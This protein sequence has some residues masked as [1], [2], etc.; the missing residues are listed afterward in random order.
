MNPAIQS[1]KQVELWHHF[2]QFHTL[3]LSVLYYC[4]FLF[5]TGPLDS[6]RSEKNLVPVALLSSASTPQHN[7]INVMMEQIRVSIIVSG[8]G[9]KAVTSLLKGLDYFA[10]KETQNQMGPLFDALR[11]ATAEQTKQEPTR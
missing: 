2:W 7:R 10:T 11:I 5:I 4:N 1:S 9:K 3:S 8:T 6:D